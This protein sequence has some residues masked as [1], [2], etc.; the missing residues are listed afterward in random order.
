ML[1]ELIDQ[2]RS[3]R[4]NVIVPIKRGVIV[5]IGKLGE[6]FGAEILGPLSLVANAIGLVLQGR[7]AGGGEPLPLLDQ[8]GDGVVFGEEK[9]QLG[10]AVDPAEIPVLI[11]RNIVPVMTKIGSGADVQFEPRPRLALKPDQCA[12]IVV[13]IA[14][15]RR[16]RALIVAEHA[17]T[18]MAGAIAQGNREVFG[19]VVADIRSHIDIV[20]IDKVQVAGNLGHHA[21]AKVLIDGLGGGS[22]KPIRVQIVAKRQ[23]AHLRDMRTAVANHRSGGKGVETVGIGQRHRVPIHGNEKA[24]QITRKIIELPFDVVRIAIPLLIYFLIMFLLSFFMSRKVGATYGQSSTL[25][26]T[27]ASNNFELAIA[28]AV[29][30]FGIHHGAA[31]AAVIGPLVEVPVMLGLVHVA[32]YFKRRLSWS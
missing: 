21:N 5:V 16:A 7:Y 18:L 22:H 17:L 19:D 24:G 1:V 2:G 29:A 6:D 25:S 27:A 9:V 31:F 20:A 23:L 14:A 26:F 28:V 12:L 3:V 13:V 30:T 15:T 8:E 4:G 11:H 10:I 32:L